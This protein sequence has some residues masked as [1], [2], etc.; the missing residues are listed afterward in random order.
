MVVS[1][2][3]TGRNLMTLTNLIGNFRGREIDKES[4]LRNGN[5]V[6]M[7]FQPTVDMNGGDPL[8]SLDTPRNSAKAILICRP[9]SHPFS[10]RTLLL[11]QSV[12][13]GRSVAK[14][15][16]ASNNAIFDCK[17]LS[18]NH[19]LM[20][21]ENGKFYLKDVKSSNGTF[22]NNQRLS[23][24]S[25][26]SAPREICSG[27]IVQFGVDV[28]ENTKRVT[29]G[30]II[31]T[32]KLF[33][34]DGKEA[35]ASLL[36]TA[37]VSAFT[38]S[39]SVQDMHQLH[40]CIQEALRRE[41][42]L[43]KKLVFLEN[44]LSRTSA[45]THLNWKA[46]IDEDRLLTRVEVLESLLQVYSKNFTEDKLRDELKKCYEDKETYQTTAKETLCN[47][48]HEKAELMAKLKETERLASSHSE[49]LGYFKDLI[50]QRDLEMEALTQSYEKEV[51]AKLE[52][53]ARLKEI[54]GQD[55]NTIDKCAVDINGR[56]S[57]L[58]ED[59]KSTTTE[60]SPSC[61]SDSVYKGLTSS[62]L[63]NSTSSLDSSGTMSA[64]DLSVNGYRET[65]SVGTQV[66][67]FIDSITESMD[68]DL[69]AALRQNEESVMELKE[70]EN[71]ALTNL[72]KEAKDEVA[73]L[74]DKPV[75]VE[76][77][78]SIDKAL[79][80]SDDAFAELK[81]LLARSRE[82]K[83]EL[84]EEKD[85][86][87]VQ[88]T[89]ELMKREKMQSDLAD[90]EMKFKATDID[91]RCLEETVNE[92]RRD[93]NRVTEALEE[94]EKEADEFKLRYEAQSETAERLR[95]EL[96]RSVSFPIAQRSFNDGA[97]LE[98]P[99]MPVQSL[100][101]TQ[102]SSRAEIKAFSLSMFENSA[103]LS[104]LPSFESLSD[105]VQAYKVKLMRAKESFVEYQ[106]MA[107]NL[108][109]DNEDLRRKLDKLKTQSEFVSMSYKAVV[110][111]LCGFFLGMAIES[112]YN[113]VGG[114]IVIP[115][116]MVVISVVAALY[117]TVSLLT[118]TWD[119][120]GPQQGN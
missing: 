57:L 10:E 2:S 4:Q 7:P 36:S 62:S 82:E 105:E 106:R 24:G 12:K 108:K 67:Q 54:E 61:Q 113:S 31:A 109:R 52:M 44:L 6:T 32:V 98:L 49:D 64:S 60:E 118:G 79:P 94:S 3:E 71:S 26:E 81:K 9:N 39:V 95:L 80:A 48:L 45:S 76:N 43:Q 33:L 111:L 97:V 96:T 20:W 92:I 72:L 50:S 35:K 59:L 91:R 47:V 21:Y 27:D 102:D 16:A 77:V 56:S 83:K 15:R 110:V 116:L 86:L 66:D 14:A 99:G 120:D 28:V 103:D 51:Q 115:V 1:S 101:A 65:E 112:M 13:I 87:K 38:G 53:E 107:V 75:T 17:V 74:K 63:T 40:H 58:D 42:Q 69:K 93:L 70:H 55:V 18:R 119:S 5:A 84:E 19:A 46:L 117:P 100:C 30:C 73:M 78:T 85:V 68:S 41:E 37:V 8:D 88:L 89:E 29:H 11:D 104:D 22:V 90:L 25:E 23:K 34:P 114:F